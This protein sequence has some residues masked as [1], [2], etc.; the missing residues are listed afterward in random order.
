VKGEKAEVIR[1]NTSVWSLFKIN[2]FG[3]SIQGTATR[4]KS[5]KITCSNIFFNQTK[6]KKPSAIIPFY[7]NWRAQI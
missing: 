4:A 3:K 1:C 6:E 5:N 2:G 7:L